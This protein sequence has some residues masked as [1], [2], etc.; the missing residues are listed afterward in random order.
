MTYDIKCRSS[1]DGP[2]QFRHSFVIGHLIVAIRASVSP[3]PR[4]AR[5]VGIYRVEMVYLEFNVWITGPQ[6][7]LPLAF[8]LALQD[9]TNSL[10]KNP[11]QGEHRLNPVC[12][13]LV[14]LYL[15]NLLETLAK[16]GIGTILRD[17]NATCTR[18]KGE[19]PQSC[20]P[21]LCRYGIGILNELPGLQC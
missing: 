12:R 13:D 19:G 2:V 20:G 9:C 10:L 4:V 16:F 6:I 15:R 7:V 8:Q 14:R 5:S 18:I 17:E 3:Y 11:R 1:G 21:F